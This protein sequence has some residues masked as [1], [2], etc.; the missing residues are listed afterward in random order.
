MNHWFHLGHTLKHLFD[1]D[2]HAQASGDPRQLR[3]VA[4][5]YIVVGIF[6]TPMLIGIPM[7][8]YGLYKLKE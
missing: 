1:S 6:L 5:G 2:R 7:T 4:Y 8:L 3:S